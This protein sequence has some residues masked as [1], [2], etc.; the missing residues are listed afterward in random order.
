VLAISIKLTTSTKGISR[1]ILKVLLN[2]DQHFFKIQTVNKSI[3]QP[4]CKDEE[5]VVNS[6]CQLTQHKLTATS[7]F[8]NGKYGSI[9]EHF[10]LNSL[11]TSK[12]SR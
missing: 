8:L 5:T 11:L 7:D 10:L 4:A 1:Q 9:H 12:D 6:Y 2:N 3:K